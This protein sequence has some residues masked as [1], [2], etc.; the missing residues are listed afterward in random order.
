MDHGRCP[1]SPVSWLGQWPAPDASK[2]DAGNPREDSY[3]IRCPWIFQ[4]FFYLIT[5]LKEE[6]QKERRVV[7]GVDFACFAKVHPLFKANVP[8]QHKQRLLKTLSQNNCH[9]FWCFNGPCPPWLFDHYVLK[10]FFPFLDTPVP[11]APALEFRVSASQLLHSVNYNGKNFMGIYFDLIL[12][13]LLACLH[14]RLFFTSATALCRGSLPEFTA[15]FA[16][17]LKRAQAQWRS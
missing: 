15:H 8:V 1:S 11:A 4:A 3:A 14:S 7:S 16:A 5:F 2:G 9:D 13:P 12:L 17:S 10:Y 6:N